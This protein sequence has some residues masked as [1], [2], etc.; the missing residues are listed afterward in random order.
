MVHSNDYRRLHL[1]STHVRIAAAAV[2]HICG[3][4]FVLRASTAKATQHVEQRWQAGEILCP[5]TVVHGH[6]KV[7]A[8]PIDLGRKKYRVAIARLR[9]C[10]VLW[11]NNKSLWQQ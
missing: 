8:I 1:P 11:N 5:I 9:L 10:C 4:L 6:A 3:I 7:Q 2:E